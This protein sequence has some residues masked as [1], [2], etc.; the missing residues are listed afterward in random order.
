MT[1]HRYIITVEAIIEAPASVPTNQDPNEQSLANT[2][3]G[4]LRDAD[5]G[6]SYKIKVTGLKVTKTQTP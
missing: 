2:I 4:K 5:V 6:G 1:H 3:S